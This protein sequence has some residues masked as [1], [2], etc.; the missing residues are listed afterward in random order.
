MAGTPGPNRAAE[1]SAN[2]GSHRT[3]RSTLQQLLALLDMLRVALLAILIVLS[4]WST[5]TDLWT[6]WMADT[7]EVQQRRIAKNL[8]LT[9]M[10]GRAIDAAE[11]RR[12]IQEAQL[13][14]E[15]IASNCQTPE[16]RAILLERDR[17]AT[18]ERAGVGSGMTQ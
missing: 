11:V 2:T 18:R 13:S 8:D 12:K 1:A 17:N 10:A 9:Y 7:P 16:V 14:V 4:S 15:T 6:R 3:A 5:W